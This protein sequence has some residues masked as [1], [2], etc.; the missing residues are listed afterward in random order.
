MKSDIDALMKARNLD[1]IFV[2]GGE[3]QN[4]LRY[5]MTNGAALSGGYVI[6]KYGEKPML[7]INPM[8]AEEAKKTGYAIRNYKELGAYSPYYLPAQERVEFWATCLREAGIESGCIG[9]YGQ[10]ELETYVELV[11]L[12]NSHFVQYQFVGE[13]GLTLFEEAFVTKDAD[14][15]AIMLSV[16][17]RT[18][19]VMAS[20][21]DF[22][23]SHTADDSETVIKADGS[24][25]T[26]ADVKNHVRVE[27]ARRGLQDN[28]M[29]F[30]QGRDAGFPH[31]RGENSMALK[32]GQSIVFDLFPR[33]I[34]GGYYHDMTRTW[35]IGYAPPQVQEAY[36]EVM[37]AFDIAIEDFAINKPLYT[38]QEA[39]QDFFED[40]GHPTARSHPK[41]MEGYVHGLGHGVGLIIHERPSISHIL[42][43]D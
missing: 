37:Q 42:R 18:N 38:M 3:G 39:V 10:G 16:A 31:S 1:A 24:P 43:D 13:T 6:Q 8:E 27:L 25:L 7:I 34:G 40:K 19:D 36:D 4:V 17:E 28:G 23:A 29:T 41:T 9:I 26:I 30:A 33:E 2:T 14:E 12:A 15:I 35:C 21:W 20:A 32:L 5:Y 11:K 22:I